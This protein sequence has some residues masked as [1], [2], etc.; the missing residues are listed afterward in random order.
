MLT[1]PELCRRAGPEESRYGKGRAGVRQRHAQ[2]AAR[3]EDGKDAAIDNFSYLQAAHAT[4]ARPGSVSG[5]SPATAPATTPTSAACPRAWTGN[6]R[7]QKLFHERTTW[8]ATK[9][10]FDCAQG[11]RRHEE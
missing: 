7:H 10:P 4:G 8:S 9:T 11:R 6:W 3:P 1:F 2:D 5:N